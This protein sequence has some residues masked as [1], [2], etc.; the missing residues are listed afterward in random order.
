M[1][2]DNYYAFQSG[3]DCSGYAAAYVLRN[4][5]FEVEGAELYEEFDR[6]FGYVAVHNIVDK[7]KEYEIKAHAYHGNMETLKCRLNQ[8]KPVVALVTITIDRPNGL[9]YLAVVGYDEEYIYAADSTR[10]ATNVY[11]KKQYNRKLTY[12]Q[13]EEI[14]DTDIYPVNNVYIVVD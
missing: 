8:G 1:Q 5:G 12:E 7:L 9:H 6:F 14:W 4:Q 11:D 2:D 10:P 13:F 3:A